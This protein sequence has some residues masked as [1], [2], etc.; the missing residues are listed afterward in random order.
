MKTDGTAESFEERVSI[1]MAYDLTPREAA[2]QIVMA[3]DRALILEARLAEANAA[4]EAEQTE[5]WKM[6]GR[7]AEAEAKIKATRDDLHYRMLGGDECLAECWRC[8]CEKHY[9]ICDTL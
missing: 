6:A 3:T 5:K 1:V 4:F 8:G 9:C 2:C 7:L